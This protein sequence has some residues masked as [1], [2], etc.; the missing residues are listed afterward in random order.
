MA[1]LGRREFVDDDDG[2][3]DR[4]P[5]SLSGGSMV[6]ARCVGVIG[7]AR[8]F[9]ILMTRADCITPNGGKEP[10]KGNGEAVRTG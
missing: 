2:V 5:K 8:G 3:V 1:V 9:T 6:C 7:C 10:F 4:D